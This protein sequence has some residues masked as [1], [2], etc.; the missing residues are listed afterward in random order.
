VALGV[1]PDKGRTLYFTFPGGVKSQRS[2]VTF[3]DPQNVPAFD[4]DEAW[5]EVEQVEGKPW[6]FWRA[7]RRV[8]G[9]PGA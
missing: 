4:G 1:G 9:P 5:F 8:E 3:V 2:N 7:V 6:A